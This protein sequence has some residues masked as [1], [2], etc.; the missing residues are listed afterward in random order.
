M[1]EKSVSNV[2][3]SAKV[4]TVNLVDFHCKTGGST[5]KTMLK[6]H[7]KNTSIKYDHMSSHIITYHHVIPRF[8][9][10]DHWKA[11]R[12]SSRAAHCMELAAATRPSRGQRGQRLG[13]N[14]C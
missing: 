9:R 14:P 1:I 11:H 2:H 5:L 10:N 3:P 13:R 8:S 4:D 12:Q 7:Y 6:R